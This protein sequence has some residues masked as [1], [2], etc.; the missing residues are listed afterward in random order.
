MI[1]L[2]YLLPL[3][4][5][6]WKNSLRS[7]NLNLKNKN[8]DCNDESDLDEDK[9]VEDEAE[10]DEAERHARQQEDARGRMG[11]VRQRLCQAPTGVSVHDSENGEDDEKGQGW[12][13]AVRSVTARCRAA[14]GWGDYTYSMLS[15]GRQRRSRQ[16]LDRV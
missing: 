1:V 12:D 15:V 11:G 6:V 3:L 14:V 8:R 9:S 2:L 5:C 16:R 7:K 10:P 4:S 13:R